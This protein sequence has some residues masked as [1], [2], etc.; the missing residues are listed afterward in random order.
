MTTGDDTT[1]DKP[2]RETV[3]FPKLKAP[4]PAQ[5]RRQPSPKEAAFEGTQKLNRKAKLTDQYRKRYKG[6]H[7][8][9]E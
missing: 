2:E 4:R 5:H 7:R 9:G 1:Q 6:K 3:L 8:K